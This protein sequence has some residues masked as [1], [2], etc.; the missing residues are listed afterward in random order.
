MS[1]TSL[2]SMPRQP[3]RARHLPSARNATKP[4]TYMRPYQRTANGPRLK[5]MGS[6]WGWV[7]KAKKNAGPKPRIIR[8]SSA[9]HPGAHVVPIAAGAAGRDHGAAARK[10]NS[11]T[12]DAR[13]GEKHAHHRVHRQHAEQLAVGIQVG[14]ET[15][16]AQREQGDADNDR[17]CLHG[18][19]LEGMSGILFGPLALQGF[20]HVG[21][22]MEY[23]GAGHVLQRSNRIGPWPTN[24]DPSP[25]PRACRARPTARC[26]ARSATRTPTSKSPSSA[27]PTAT[28]R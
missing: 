17:D 3:W 13:D 23:R 14:H 22:C 6:N 27:S 2:G 12:R 1:S 15:R 5:T 10:A 28:R 7:S 11:D 9:L 8:Q 19:L 21:G 20:R 25:S 18:R 26:C 4:T 24:T 16:E